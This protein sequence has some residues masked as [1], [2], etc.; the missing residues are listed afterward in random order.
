MRRSPLALVTV[1][2]AAWPATTADNGFRPAHRVHVNR[3]RPRTTAA[4]QSPTCKGSCAMTY[5]GGKVLANVKVYQVNWT[6]A[7]DAAVAGALPGFYKAVTNSAY[8]DWLAE[9]DTNV[10]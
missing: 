5:F 1:L 6:S 3:P 10:D 7:V 9:Y 4:T 8:L 2:C